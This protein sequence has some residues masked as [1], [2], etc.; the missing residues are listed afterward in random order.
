MEKYINITDDDGHWYYL[1][2]S[3]KAE[4]MKML[5]EGEQDEWGAF[6]DKFNQYRTGGGP[7]E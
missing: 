2:K 3:M 6:M 7:H 5:E 4:F 1:P